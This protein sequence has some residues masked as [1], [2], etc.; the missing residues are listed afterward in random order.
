MGTCLNP[1][2]TGSADR[3]Q[4]AAAA[5]QFPEP[6]MRLMVEDVR[7]VRGGRLVLAG[8]GARLEAGRALLV[9]GPN[10]AGKSTLLRAI[11]GLLR[12]EAGSISL[13][14]G[15]AERSVGEQAHFVGHLDAVKAA[16]S[17]AENLVFWRDMLGGEGDVGAALDALGLGRL[18]ELPA[19]VLSAGQRRRLAL[20]RL[21]VAP[22]PLW[23]L[24]EPTTALDAASQ[25]KFAG[26]VNAHLAGGGLAVVA[27]HADTG[28]GP[29]DTLELRSAA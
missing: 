16:L 9:T 23:L 3:P 17:V 7:C 2:Q 27:T 18:L 12:L 10:G 14:G 5:R 13:V 20:A 11:A 15:D 8:V 19:S 21:L 25:E 28:I 4:E 29:A 22:R 26:L 1:F 24:D 6:A